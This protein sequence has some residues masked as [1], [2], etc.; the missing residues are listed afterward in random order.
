[1]LSGCDRSSRTRNM[2]RTSCSVGQWDGGWEDLKDR[3]ETRLIHTVAIPGTSQRG[4]RAPKQSLDR[5]GE[6]V[7]DFSLT[8]KSLGF[9]LSTSLFL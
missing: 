9:P 1:M 8:R 7:K 6:K 3:W 4:A 2:A 5:L